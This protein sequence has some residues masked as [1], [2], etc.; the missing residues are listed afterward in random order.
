MAEPTVTRTDDGSR[1]EVHVDDEL[2]GFIE[3][4]T[5]GDRAAFTHTEVFEAHRGGGVAGTLAHGAI[6]DATK[7]GLVIVP[8][9]AYIAGYLDRHEI[10]G[11]RVE[12]P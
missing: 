12:A 6:T 4:K 3:V 9:C 5:D 1:Y 11:V 10:E 2:A 7:R 8:Q